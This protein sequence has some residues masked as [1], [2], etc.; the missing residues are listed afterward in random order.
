MSAPVLQA[1]S[2]FPDDPLTVSCETVSENADEAFVDEL[3]CKLTALGAKTIV[4]TGVAFEEGKTG[5]MVYEN[6]EKWNYVHERIAKGC[7]GT[8]D[9]Y[10]SA[11]TGALMNGKTVREAAR[12]AADYVVDCIKLTQGDADHWYGVKFELGIPQLLRYLGK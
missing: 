11:F 7:H 4:M 2:P 3:L 8:G 5:V 10:A 1:S 6:G 9:V 12:I